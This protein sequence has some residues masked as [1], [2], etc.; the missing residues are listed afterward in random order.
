MQLCVQIVDLMNLEGVD[1]SA[2]VG[3]NPGFSWLFVH[4]P[5]HQVDMQID[6]LIFERL[7]SCAA[8]EAASSEEQPDIIPMAGKGYTVGLTALCGRLPATFTG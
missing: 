6:N 7:R 8:V 2:D 5:P 1:L 3:H 4:L